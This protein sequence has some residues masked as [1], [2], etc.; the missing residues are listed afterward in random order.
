MLLISLESRGLSQ[1]GFFDTGLILNSLQSI[2]ASTIPS[3]GDLNPYG[4][5]FVPAGFPPGGSIAAGDLLVVNFNNNGNLQGIRGDFD[6]LGRCRAE[7]LRIRPDRWR[8]AWSERSGC[9]RAKELRPGRE[10]TARDRSDDLPRR[11]NRSAV[12][13]KS[14]GQAYSIRGVQW[15]TFADGKF[16]PYKD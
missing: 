13:F 14:T 10:P 16:D 8:L 7:H 6:A 2:T 9:C 15:F 3:N 11:L 4:V 12:M 1:N 5:A